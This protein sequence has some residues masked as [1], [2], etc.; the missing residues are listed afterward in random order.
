MLAN[1]FIYIEVVYSFYERCLCLSELLCVVS[2]ETSRGCLFFVCRWGKF[3]ALANETSSFALRRAISHT[4]CYGN[5]TYF[6]AFFLSRFVIWVLRA[7]KYRQL[8]A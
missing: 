4:V 1:I 2:H 5:K 3:T 8:R 6:F 7:H